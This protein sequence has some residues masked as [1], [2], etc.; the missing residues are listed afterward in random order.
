M[1]PKT[2]MTIKIEKNIET[3]L[4]DVKGIDEVVEEIEQ[5]IRVI[6]NP[7]KYRNAG[8]K[9]PK[10]VLLVG[11]PGTGKTLAAKA[12]AG[13]SKV[14]F[15][16]VS[17]SDFEEKYVGVGASRVKQLFATAK[18][19]APCIIFIDEI[20]SLLA[21]SKRTTNEH[22]SSRATINQFLTEMDG[23]NKL[24]NI[25]ILGATN[26]ESDLDSAAVRP[27]RFDKKIHIN[28]PNS[29]GRE[30]IAEY[31][32][33]KI[34]LPKNKDVTPSLISQM[35]SGFTGAELENLINLS[36]IFT[37]NN[38]QKEIDLSVVTEAR[39]RILMG[40]SRKYVTDLNKRRFMT[41][42]HEVGHTYACY[43]NPLCRPR[44]L[45]VTII[46][47]GPALGVTQTLELD[48]TVENKEYY[49]SFVDM[50][51]GGHTAEECIFGKDNVTAGCSSDLS[52]A[53]QIAKKMIYEMSMYGEEIGYIYYDKGSEIKEEKLGEKHKII[54]NQKVD[55]ILAE[56]HERVKS[57][58]NDNMDDVIKLSRALY[59]YNTLD[60]NEIELV[61][62]N[63]LNLIK[64][65][66]SREDYSEENSEKRS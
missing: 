10:G 29:K 65:T 62:N 17:G 15:I 56:S 60:A 24:E 13:D 61:L 47:S 16:S 36:G 22:S 27:G 4:K 25:F 9:I 63:K 48:D 5:L 52:K 7:D 58:L 2:K 38:K 49:L 23:F 57:L 18:K 42:V 14:N 53:T 20:D 28:V 33:N 35:T 46:P 34:L 64:R 37:I 31:Y 59:R 11:K 26:H 8:A 54:L 43:K 1:E 45:K 6:K 12:I 44:I 50:A 66:E 32:L 30:D 21:K 40:I 3:S 41:A 51:M 19:N 55:Q 39:D